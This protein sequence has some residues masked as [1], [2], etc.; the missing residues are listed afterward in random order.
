M[1]RI[2]TWAD[3]NLQGDKVIW[4]LVSWLFTAPLEPLRTN[5]LKVPNMD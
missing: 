1:E 5:D 4:A 3:K 2:K